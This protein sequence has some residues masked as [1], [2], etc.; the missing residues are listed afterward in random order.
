[1]REYRIVDAE[2]KVTD[3]Y[4]DLET[5]RTF[6]RIKNITH[7]GHTVRIFPP[8]P[9]RP[10]EIGDEYMDGSGYKMKITKME[11]AD[12]TLYVDD[13]EGRYGDW[14]GHGAIFWIDGFKTN[15]QLI[16]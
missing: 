2:G 13:L 9:D 4:K 8:L 15:M 3:T 12:N 7:P 11:I 14:K 16:N 1:M 5:A 6:R 10:F